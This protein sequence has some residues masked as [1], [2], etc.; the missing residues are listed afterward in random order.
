MIDK[1]LP[2]RQ[3]LEHNVLVADEHVAPAS[4]AVEA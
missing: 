2:G 3:K 1:E 4:E